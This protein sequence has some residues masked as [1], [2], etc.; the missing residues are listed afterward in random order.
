MFGYFDA[1][2]FF[3]TSIHELRFAAVWPHDTM[4]YLP[5]PPIFSASASTMAWPM[6]SA[7]AWLAKTSREE[8][9][10]SDPDVAMWMSFALASAST[11]AIES[12]S[13]GATNKVLTFCWISDLT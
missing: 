11:G 13:L 7:V 4:A 9:G 1:V 3:S 10:A 5:L 12:G 2:Y 8:F 6:P